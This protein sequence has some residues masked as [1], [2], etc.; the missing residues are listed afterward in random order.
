MTGEQSAEIAGRCPGCGSVVSDRFQSCQ[1][2]NVDTTQA[3]YRY[4][5][6]TWGYCLHLGKHVSKGEREWL[7]V[8]MTN[9]AEWR[10]DSNEDAEWAVETYLREC[11]TPP[12][13]PES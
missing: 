11:V 8:V 10:G 9:F 12:E 5:A 13:R 4:L 1:P 6:N 2:I 7:A 3:G